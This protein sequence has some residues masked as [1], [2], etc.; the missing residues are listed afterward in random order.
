MDAAIEASETM[1]NKWA[2][3]KWFNGGSSGWKMLAGS[4]RVREARVKEIG[5]RP[6]SFEELIG[7][8]QKECESV[9]GIQ[10]EGRRKKAC[11]QQGLVLVLKN[12]S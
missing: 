3:E 9:R 4:K 2:R 11:E 7:G 5:R 6:R 12:A 1:S 8:L 10:L